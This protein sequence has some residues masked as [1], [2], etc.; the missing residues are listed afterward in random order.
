MAFRPAYLSLLA[1]GEL[2]RRVELAY[3][4]L[5]ACD[6]CAWAC[7][8]NRRAGQLGVCRTGEKAKVSS[9]GPHFGEEA[10]LR[11]WRG[12]GT[13]FFTRCNLRC[14]YCQNYEISQTDQGQEVEPE[15]LAEIMLH[16]QHLGC[17]NINLVSPSHVVAQILLPS[18]SPLKPDCASPWSITRAAMTQWKV[19]ACWMGSLIFTCRI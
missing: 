11:G 17:H 10:P 16:L 6:L 7:G 9:Y 8:V 3:A 15:E 1:S 18:S 4:H 19:Y 5:E 2:K 13:I 12:S 14:Q